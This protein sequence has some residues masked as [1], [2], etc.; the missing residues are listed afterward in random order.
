MKRAAAIAALLLALAGP[1]AAAQSTWISADW[2]F[3]EYLIDTGLKKDAATL[4]A[5]DLYFPSDTLTYLR[6]WS[7]YQLQD[8]EPALEL[9][10][11]VPEDSPFA[12]KSFF[13][14]NAVSA[15]LGDYATPAALLEAYGGPY[16]ELRGVQLA[17][18]ALLRDD[19]AAFKSARESFGYSDFALVEAERK[20]DE[21]YDFRYVRPA[22]SPLLAAAA[23]AV[24][25]GLGKIYAGRIGEGIESFLITGVSGAVAANYWIKDGPRDWKTI[26]ASAVCAI[27]YIGN[28]YGSY[29]SVSIYNNNVKDVQDTAILYNIHI[30]LRSVFK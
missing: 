4:L 18:L 3:A 15:H 17:G 1:R 5:Q 2:D 30:P 11:A 21:I 24:V 27:L 19:P 13:Y 22:K 10:R 12:Q 6:G 29:V 16:K 8:L 7:A 20:L 28:I 26:A 23:S 14:G 25:P 9:L